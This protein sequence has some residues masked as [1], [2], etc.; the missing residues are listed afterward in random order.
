MPTYNDGN[1]PYGFPGLVGIDTT[2]TDAESPNEFYSLE[3]ITTE[4]AGSEIE[5]RSGLNVVTGRVLIQDGGNG[6]PENGP[7][8]TELTSATIR[9][10]RATITQPFP[11]IGSL[12]LMQGD[13][14]T[15][16]LISTPERGQVW[17]VASGGQNYAQAEA[18]T[19]E[20]VCRPTQVVL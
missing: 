14:G 1:V 11:P 15:A 13:G 7:Y 2:G 19:F 12:F 18:H 8:S 5:R 3:S 4:T 10:Q 16:D 20:V 6:Q 17:C 9:L